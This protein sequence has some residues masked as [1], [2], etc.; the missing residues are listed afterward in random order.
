MRTPTKLLFTTKFVVHDTCNSPVCMHLKEFWNISMSNR[1]PWPSCVFGSRG[2]RLNIRCGRWPILCRCSAKFGAPHDV[3]NE[4]ME[5][6]SFLL[7]GIQWIARQSWLGCRT[8]LH[9]AGRLDNDIGTI[10]IVL[11]I[12]PSSSGRKCH[13]T[14]QKA[15]WISQKIAGIIVSDLTPT[16][17]SKRKVFFVN[18]GPVVVRC[19]YL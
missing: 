5:I 2:R 16:N 4:Y 13:P 15:D 6:S 9:I 11:A 14:R 12:F 10:D 18:D 17:A 8:V 3:Y 1:P 7:C 19:N